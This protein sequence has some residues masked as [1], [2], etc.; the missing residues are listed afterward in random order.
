MAW[1][2]TLA[3]GAGSSGTL[4][5]V[6]PGASNSTWE[7]QLGCVHLMSGDRNRTVLV[8]T[9][10]VSPLVTPGYATIVP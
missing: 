1:S 9:P 6:L 5:R 7:V 10:V 3:L 8:N 2:I 4:A